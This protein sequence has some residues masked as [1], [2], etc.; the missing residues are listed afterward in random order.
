MAQMF[1]SNMKVRAMKMINGNVELDGQNIES[2]RVFFVITL[3]AF[4]LLGS[5]TAI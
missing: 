1:L 3:P 4:Q 5:A 2:E